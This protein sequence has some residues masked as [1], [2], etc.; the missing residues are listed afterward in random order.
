MKLFEVR[1]AEVKEE[2]TNHTQ[3][4]LYAGL[5]TKEVDEWKEGMQS[6]AKKW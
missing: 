3:Q 5:N 1:F 4:L 2:Q 6:I